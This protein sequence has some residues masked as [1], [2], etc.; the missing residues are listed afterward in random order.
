[1]PNW[2]ENRVEVSGE[3]ER[4]KS[5]V[6]AVKSEESAFDF[7]KIMATPPDLLNVVADGKNYSWYQWRLEHWGTKWNTDAPSCDNHG[8]L[9][10]YHFDTAWSPP[11]GI[12]KLV[13]DQWPDLSITWFYNEPGMA[14]AGYL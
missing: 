8:D 13:R 4:V 5:F 14:I 10:I 2:C 1:M 9:A 3:G 12:C 11:E 7:E 6:E